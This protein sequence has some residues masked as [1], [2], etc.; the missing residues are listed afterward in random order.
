M[1]AQAWVQPEGSQKGGVFD[2]HDRDDV[3][4][5]RKQFLEKFQELDAKTI[6]PDCPPPELEEGEKAFIRVVHD[7]STFYANADQTSFWSDG[8]MQQLRQKSLGAS[9]MVSDFITEGDGYL[10][11][12]SG[13]ARLLVEPSWDGYFN[14]DSFLDQVDTALDVFERKYPNARGVFL[15]DNAPCHKKC[16]PDGLNAEH[17]KVKP[18]G[19]QSVVCDTVW[20]GK[21]QWM[22]FPDGTPKGKKC[23]L[24]ERGVNTSSMNAAKMRECLSGHPDFKNQA[25]LLQEKVQHW[26]ASISRSSIVKSILLIVIG[27]M[28]KKYSRAHVNG[29]IVRLR[30]AVPNALETVMKEMMGKFYKMCRD[31]ERA[32]RDGHTGRDVE[33]VIKSYKSH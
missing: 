7:E 15:F 18:G 21:V 19:K 26:F 33:V 16:P 14:N 11:D 22:V 30:E 3:V 13:S 10:Q 9:I 32:Y 1:A 25:T 2:R 20:E 17:M 23:V 24:E 5:Y 28:Q 31:Y 12:E 29:S 6:I 8:T 4:E 27:A